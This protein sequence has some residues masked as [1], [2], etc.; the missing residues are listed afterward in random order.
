MSSAARC[1]RRRRAR[2]T[3]SVAASGGVGVRKG[4]AQPFAGARRA[5]VIARAALRRSELLDRDRRRVRRVWD[6]RA[7]QEEVR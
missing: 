4:F 5:P 7:G 1:A 3:A 6:I 2:R